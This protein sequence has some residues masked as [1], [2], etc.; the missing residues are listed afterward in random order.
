[1]V[2]FLVTALFIC[3]SHLALG[4]ALKSFVHQNVDPLRSALEVH[5]EAKVEEVLRLKNARVV[6]ADY[7]LIREDFP[8]LSGLSHEQIDNWLLEETAYISNGQKAQTTVNSFIE[9]LHDNKRQAL[10]PPEYG[11]A[12]VY[13]VAWQGEKIG[14]LD[15][16]GAGGIKPSHASHRSGTMTLGESLREF[17]YEKMITSVVEHSGIQNKVVGSYA[18][19]D[20][21][22]D[23]IHPDGSSS[24]GGFYLRQGHRRYTKAEN[25]ARGQPLGNGWMEAPWRQ[26]FDKL[27]SRYGIWANENYQ[28]TV[29]NDLFDF[30]HYII[31]EDLS[32]L[33]GKLAVPF[34][35]WGFD[36]APEEPIASMDDRWKFSKRDRPWIWSHDTAQAFAQGQASRHHVWLHHYNLVNPVQE[37]LEKTP[38]IYEVSEGLGFAVKSCQR[39]FDV[40]GS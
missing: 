14:V 26:R 13:E 22:F 39:V 10:R 4:Q 16:K 33:D 12:L 31:R 8:R 27:L 32:D 1:M 11:R 35:R 38:R 7:D 28:G 5:P 30:G 25:M 34:E 15:V 9:T 21:G 20:P 36:K 37:K 29:N 6:I 17:S 3:F 40:P 23:V 2:K 18:V 24:R 19:I